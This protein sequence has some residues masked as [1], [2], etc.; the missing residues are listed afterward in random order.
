M[1]RGLIVVNTHDPE[2]LGII[3]HIAAT[4]TAAGGKI[5]FF[6]ITNGLATPTNAFHEPT[7]NFFRINFTNDDI[8]RSLNRFGH[9][10]WLRE[11]NSEPKLLSLENEAEIEIAVKSVIISL[12]RTD[13]PNFNSYS[14]KM[15][16]ARLK[17]H[18]RYVYSVMHQFLR[19]N[20]FDYVYIF[21]GRAPSQKAVTLATLDANTKSVFF[22][23]G[24][25]PGTA[26]IRNYTPHDRIISQKSVDEVLFGISQKLIQETATSWLAKRAPAKN[27]PNQ[28]SENW[29][30]NLPQYLLSKI[31]GRKVAGFFTSSQDEFNSI[32]PEWLIHEWTS[33]I[34]AFEVLANQL[35]AKNYVCFLRVHPNLTS[36]SH[37][38][39][40]R[41][42]RD[43]IELQKRNPE[44]IIL[45]HDNP[46]NTYE[47]LTQT[48]VVVVWN[49]TVGIEASARGIPVYTCAAASYDLTADVRTAYGSKSL[50]T[51]NEVEWEVDKNA[52]YRYIAYTI[53]RDE[54]IR[55][56]RQKW[57]RWDASNPPI[58]A[59][60]SALFVS[61]GNA[62]IRESIQFNL[63]VWRH[64]SFKFN[65]QTLKKRLSK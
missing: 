34:E 59:K 7:L 19:K 64:R 57:V 22:E 30:L 3:E 49:S 14:N 27:S 29:A 8:E 6:D 63:D 16:S 65:L 5:E 4:R 12:K 43:I 42:R 1:E 2:I 52:A 40:K 39:F 61:G 17:I 38:F 31:S 35:K 46:I 60:L 9:V 33:Q 25:S 54:V 21:N 51:Y 28:F 41:E 26:F 37:Q 18:S 13:S 44:L 45:W 15:L 62:T 55:I 56:S 53:F 32:G 48:D 47:L 11:I 24:D 10:N 58:A 36:K 20:D 23:K 50:N